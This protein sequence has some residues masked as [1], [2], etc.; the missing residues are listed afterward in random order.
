MKHEIG[1]LQFITVAHENL[2]HS[3]QAIRAIRSGC[4]WVQ[5]RMKETNDDTIIAEAKRIL[6]VAE[7]HNAVL[8]INDRADIAL[9]CRAHGVHLGKSDVTVTEARKILGKG[10]IIGATANTLDDI[11]SLAI[12]QPYYIG[13]GPFRFTTTKKNLSPILGMEGYRTILSAMKSLDIRIPVVAIGGIVADDVADI[14]STGVHGIA[15][16][17]A[18]VA[19]EAIEENTGLYLEKLK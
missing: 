7:A 3:E 13:L 6:P 2:S 17:G 14:L 5:L 15:L 19:N 4:R 11:K 12:Q 8:I 18:I 9:K 1:K 10:K 16:A